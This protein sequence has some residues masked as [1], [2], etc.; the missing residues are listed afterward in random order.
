MA[1]KNNDNNP[2]K[3]S[4]RVNS[5]PKNITPK[6]YYSRLIQFITDGRELPKSWNVEIGWRNPKTHH[7][8]TRLWRWDDFESAVSDSREGFNSILLAVLQ[9]RLKRFS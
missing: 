4:L 9:D 1:R 3:L 8:L 2:I 5:L 7:G 6:R